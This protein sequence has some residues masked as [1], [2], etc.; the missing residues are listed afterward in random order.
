MLSTL[1]RAQSTAN[2]QPNRTHQ[3]VDCSLIGRVLRFSHAPRFLDGWPRL[4]ADDRQLSL[5]VGAEEAA[6]MI[7]YVLACLV[8]VLLT[9]YLFVA[10]LFPERF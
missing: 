10:M 4:A 5:C 7:G 9:F 1:A 3:F 6:L 2:Q 8:A